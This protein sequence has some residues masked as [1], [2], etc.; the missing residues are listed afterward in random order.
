MIKTNAVGT[1]YG[2]SNKYPEY[3]HQWVATGFKKNGVK[4]S[5]LPLIYSKA[6]EKLVQKY[7][8]FYTTWLIYYLIESVL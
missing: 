5:L 1:Q 2:D 8:S 4:L 3:M 7:I 6:L